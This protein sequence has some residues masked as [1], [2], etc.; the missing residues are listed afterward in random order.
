MENRKIATPVNR[1]TGVKHPG[2]AGQSSSRPCRCPV[3]HTSQI[4][5][6]TTPQ[7]SG[8]SAE[9]DSLE[10]LHGP[11]WAGGVPVSPA[12][13]LAPGWL[14]A[15][16]GWCP[17]PRDAR[18]IRRRLPIWRR[19]RP[20]QPYRP[21]GPSVGPD[22]YRVSSARSFAASSRSVGVASGRSVTRW[23]ARRS[24]QRS[25]G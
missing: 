22:R 2:I 12:H 4:A 5:S 13:K 9:R 23:R 25:G 16:P 24:A 14:Q 8:Q 10:G 20:G 19:K 3:G 21:P 17:A 6:V 1:K 18:Q 7:W 15:G 11:Q